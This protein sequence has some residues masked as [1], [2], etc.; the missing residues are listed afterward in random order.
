MSEK[1]KEMYLGLNINGSQIGWALTDGNYNVLRLKGKDAWG[2]RDIGRCNTAQDRRLHRSSRR[3]IDRKQARVRLLRRYFADAIAEV[4]PGFY[5]RLDESKFHMEDRSVGNKQ[6]YGIFNDEDFTDK[7]YYAKYPT[8]FHLEKALVNNEPDAFDPRLVFLAL[9]NMYKHRGNFYQASVSEDSEAVMDIETAWDALCECAA[10]FE[11]DLNSNADKKKLLDTLSNKYLTAS[12]IYN[13]IIYQLGI[14]KTQKREQ[15]VIKLICGLSAKPARIFGEGIMGEQTA[16]ELSFKKANYEAKEAELSQLIGDDYMELIECAKTVHNIALLADIMNNRSSIS[17]AFVD[18]YDKHSEDLARLKA[19]LKRY[20]MQ[21][22]HKM[23]QVMEDGNYSAYVGSVS[24][25][26]VRLRRGTKKRSTDELYAS[27]KK[28][29]KKCPEE[30]P[31]VKAI[32][33]DIETETFMPKLRSVKNIVI[34]NQLYARDMRKILSNAEAYLPFLK[35]KNEYG[36]GV[37]EQ[38]LQIFSFTIPSYVG[39]L[40]GEEH[41]GE[42][43]YNIWAERKTDN[44]GEKVKG[45][46]RPW[47]LEE[48]IDVK[49]TEENY[50]R[51]MTR[52]C[53][54]IAGECSLPKQSPL[55]E[56]FTVLNEINNIRIH[57]EKISVEDKK[58]LYNSL[59]LKGKK[60][61]LNALK[62]YFVKE[63]LIEADDDTAISGINLETGPIAA[64]TTIGKFR[65]IFGDEVTKEENLKIIE[66]IVLWGTIYKENKKATK[67]KIEETYPGVFSDRKIKKILSFEFTDWGNLSRA[68]LTMR[69]QDTTYD[70]ERTI[71]DALWD[72]N[73]N[74]MMLLGNEYDYRE[75][76]ARL[77]SRDKLTLSNLSYDYIKEYLSEMS[78]SLEV[79][80][81]IWQ[82]IRI[83][84][85]LVDIAGRTPDKI[86]ID[87]SR[88]VKTTLDSS[89]RKKNLI[90]IYQKMGKEGKQFLDEIKERDDAQFLNNKLY[91]YYSQMGR[92]IYSGEKINLSALLADDNTIYDIDHIIPKWAIRDDRV[93]YNRVLTKRSYNGGTKKG[94]L[95]I[96]PVIQNAQG[97]YWRLLRSKGLIN[98]E[99]YLKLTRKNPYTAYELSE[100]INK[101]LVNKRQSTKAAAKILGELFPAPHTKVIYVKGELVSSF[102]QRCKMFSARSVNDFYRARD[103]YLD[104]VVGNVY[105]TKFTDDPYWYIKKKSENNKEPLYYQYHVNNLFEKDVIR[106]DNIAW[107]ARDNK[108]YAPTMDTVE[109]YM[110]KN[111][112]ILVKRPYIE[113]GQY[114]KATIYSAKKAKPGVYMATSSDKRL[115]DVTKY[116]GVTS[117][118][119]QCYSLVSYKIKGKDY[120]CLES[121]ATYLGDIDTIKDES[122]ANYIEKKYALLGKNVSNIR[123]IKRKV[124]FNTRVKVDGFEYWIG[125]KTND[126]IYAKNTRPLILESKWEDYSRLIDKAAARGKITGKNPE[127][128]K[129]KNLEFYDLLIKKMGFAY[130]K[131]EGKIKGKLEDNRDRFSDLEVMDQVSLLKN[132]LMW[133]SLDCKQVDLSLIEESKFCGIGKIKKNVLA[134]DSFYIIHQSITG[135]RE[136]R[137]N[138]LA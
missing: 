132:I 69:G 85:E 79:T 35:E 82:A 41:V 87:M 60:V 46:V 129:E 17:E 127:I 124:P 67:E 76:L 112:P 92:D 22:F 130:A 74:L 48:I 9:E 27:I 89:Y 65:T 38:I 53:T 52:R 108:E 115:S 55:Y 50:I 23:F 1:T 21:A 106:G 33:D 45:I 8:I 15:E 107:I 110:T 61:S 29:L 12:R 57:G 20:D 24:C 44:L 28:A 121:V 113:H 135:L 5:N 25:N 88:D 77:E 117:I 131:R 128:C 134:A 103:A 42:K 138:I 84:T 86:F 32:L 49:K 98:Q 63:G 94:S 39:P 116:G 122:I 133:F 114:F 64:L 51:R 93:D 109:K 83:V 73:D 101:D 100:F 119:S 126:S 3:M 111:T 37:S 125:G 70:K 99:K 90:R 2:V 11:I 118:T 62:R 123:I 58:K 13:S 30:D 102:R 105:F 104:V 36:L 71:I 14:E 136:T 47:N 137:E 97:N 96:D 91:L 81:Q 10:M 80:R 56:K 95:L 26:G 19:V 16:M 18:I 75:R 43:G 78:L 66:N 4:D 72:T 6:K 59:Y 54:Y 120:L 34:P 31:N 68:F 7:E 40:G